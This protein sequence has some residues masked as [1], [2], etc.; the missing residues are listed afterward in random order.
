[1]LCGRN[2]SVFDNNVLSQK[3]LGFCVTH[4]AH[5]IITFYKPSNAEFQNT[6]GPGVSDKGL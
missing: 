6:L 3:L 1:M 2:I 5:I 4:E